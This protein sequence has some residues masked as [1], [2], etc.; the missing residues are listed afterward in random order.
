MRAQTIAFLLLGPLVAGAAFAQSTPSPQG[1]K[2]PPAAMGTEGAEVTYPAPAKAAS[3][4]STGSDSTKAPKSPKKHTH[5]H[6]AQP[7]SGASTPQS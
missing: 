5:K 3:A 7:T 2:N 1:T 4:P 6:K